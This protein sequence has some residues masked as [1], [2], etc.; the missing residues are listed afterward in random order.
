MR[1]QGPSVI[2]GKLSSL[3]HFYSFFDGTA[4]SLFSMPLVREGKKIHQNRVDP[5]F[6]KKKNN[7]EVYITYSY[8]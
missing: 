5:N 7:I 1:L 3:S 4:K 2:T 6:K 8:R